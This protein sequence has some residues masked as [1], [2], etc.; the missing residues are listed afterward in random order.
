MDIVFED[1]K[2]AHTITDKDPKTI[3]APTLVTNLEDSYSMKR[4]QRDVHGQ[5]KIGEFR[6]MI[7]ERR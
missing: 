7:E 1:E 5:T 3:S 4:K 2:R 6:H